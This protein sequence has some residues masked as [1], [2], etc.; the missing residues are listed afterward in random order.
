MKATMFAVVLSFAVLSVPT[1]SFAQDA[2]VLAETS[3]AL[4]LNKINLN[5]ADAQALTGSFKGIGKKR[6]EAIVSYREAHD[7]FKSVADL[8]S[9]RGLGQ[10]FVNT[11]LQEL[12]GVFSVE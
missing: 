10:T 4:P 12:Q 6:A 7:G 8:A 11:H 1:P 2:K 9:V 3:V 5:K